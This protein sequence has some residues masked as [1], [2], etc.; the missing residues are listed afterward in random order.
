MVLVR[1]PLHVVEEGVSVVLDAVWR[2]DFVAVRPIVV[3]GGPGVL[4]LVASVLVD[5]AD[6]VREHPLELVGLDA[7]GAV[8]DERCVEAVIAECGP[9]IGGE[10]GAQ[11]EFSA[12]RH[13]MLCPDGDR[14]QITASPVDELD[15]LFRVSVERV[16]GDDL[17]FDPFD[18]P[19]FGLHEDIRAGAL[20]RLDSRSA[21]LN[22]LRERLVRGVDH[23]RGGEV[24][25]GL[26]P[27]RVEVGLVV[28]VEK[29]PDVVAGRNLLDVGSHRPQPRYR[30]AVARERTGA[31]A[32]LEQEIRVHAGRPPD[33]SND[34]VR[35]R[36]VARDESVASIQR[37][38]VH[39]RQL[40]AAVECHG[41]SPRAICRR[42]AFPG[43]ISI[44]LIRQTGL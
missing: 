31:V 10:V 24:K 30:V 38:V 41:R 33:Q 22:V 43:R 25:L 5:L 16:V 42:P 2:N 21:P 1:R 32:H 27:D 19:E 9:D 18:P 28:H 29:H 40:C 36:D 12:L 7:R 37:V 4:V 39:P 20:N 35:L 15:S 23:D 17:V 14:E 34:R 26:S 13:A 11:F 3:E 8:E 6:A 44:L